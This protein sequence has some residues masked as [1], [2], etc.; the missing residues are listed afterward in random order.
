VADRCCSGGLAR[1]LAGPHSRDYDT[2]SGRGGVY[3]NLF[4]QGVLPWAN[5]CARTGRHCEDMG[6]N[7][8]APAPL[9]RF[10]EICNHFSRVIEFSCVIRAAVM[11]QAR[12]TSKGSAR[13]EVACKASFLYT[14]P[15]SSSTAAPE[16]TGN[17]QTILSPSLGCRGA[18]SRRVQPSAC[19]SRSCARVAEDRSL[20]L[21]Q[22]NIRMVQVHPGARWRQHGWFCNRVVI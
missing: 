10:L 20:P 15:C 6:P 13:L 9:L 21:W 7:T 12:S 8:S 14:T 19:S 2:L 16:H 17:N 4:L 18:S 22:R 11:I 3:T 1:L 5:L